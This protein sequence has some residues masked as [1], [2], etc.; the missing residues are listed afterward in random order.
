[1]ASAHLEPKNAHKIMTKT[2]RRKLHAAINELTHAE[3]AAIVKREWPEL[4]GKKLDAIARLM[5]AQAHR[6]VSPRK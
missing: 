5:I 3:V 6:Q 1:M 2:E 4:R